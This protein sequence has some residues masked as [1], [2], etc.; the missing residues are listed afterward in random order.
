MGPSKVTAGR[1]PA[2]WQRVISLPEEIPSSVIPLDKREEREANR[3]L[4][5]SEQFQRWGNPAG[6]RVQQEGEREAQAAAPQLRVTLSWVPGARPAATPASAACLP[7]PPIPA[8]FFPLAAPVA[9][10]SGRSDLSLGLWGPRRPHSATAPEGTV[11][12][13]RAS[14][15]GKA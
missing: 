11:T 7:S 3:W 2:K 15:E 14:A 4:P 13:P 6:G 1:L 5:N 8:S 10:G 12:R 9:H